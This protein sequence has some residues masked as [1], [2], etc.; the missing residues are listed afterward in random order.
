[1][2]LW[3]IL[4]IAGAVVGLLYL[5]LEYRAS[6]WLWLV[7]IVMPAIYLYVYY[8]SGFYADM[9]INVYYLVV[10]VY[11]WTVWLGKGKG[12][13]ASG[14]RPLSISRMPRRM[15]LPAAAVSGVFFALLAWILIAFTDSTVPY[16]DAFTTAL[17]IVALWMLS[18]KY[19]EQWLV[20][21]VVDVVA[22]GLYLY[23]GLYPTAALYALYG[24]IAVSGY[25]KWLRMMK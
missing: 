22:S 24:V 8:R 17:S 12:R 16:G 19:A 6:V 2:D 9:G 1:M 7:G 15:W 13:A 10:G 3:Q 11:G 23:K 20:W 25:F 5:W 21:L 18:R 14:G 4:E